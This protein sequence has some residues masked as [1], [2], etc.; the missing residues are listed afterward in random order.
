MT[1]AAKKLGFFEGP[2]QAQYHDLRVFI[3]GVDVSGDLLGTVAVSMADVATPSTA[4]ITLDNALDKYAFT[5]DNA[6][7]SGGVGGKYRDDPF[8]RYSEEPKRKIITRKYGTD[9][10]LTTSGM[11]AKISHMLSDAIAASP[12]LSPEKFGSTTKE[13]TKQ[14]SV[15]AVK[16]VVRSLDKEFF[17]PLTE[18]QTKMMIMDAAER[19]EQL[20]SLNENEVSQQFEDE[21]ARRGAFSGIVAEDVGPLQAPS[22]DPEDQAPKVPDTGKKVGG[23]E[24][25]KQ[26]TN[27]HI[28]VGD[29]VISKHDPI[30]IYA[31]NP[32][33]ENDEWYPVFTG[34]I[35]TVTERTTETTGESTIT[36]NC[37]CIRALMQGMRISMNA[38]LAQFEPVLVIHDAGYF[39][40]QTN[41]N[42]SAWS[43]FLNG[44][45]LEQ[46]VSQLVIGKIDSRLNIGPNDSVIGAS[47]VKSGRVGNFTM[48]D[49]LRYPE[50]A[51]KRSIPPSG[52]AA[53]GVP[54]STGSDADADTLEKWHTISL[55]GYPRLEDGSNKLGTFLTENQVKELGEASYTSG[56]NDPWNRKLH[57]LLPAAGTN[58][59]T[60]TKVSTDDSQNQ[61]VFQNRWEI[62]RT[63]VQTLD[64]QLYTSP[65]GDLLLEF[66][67]YDFVP[68]DFGP[69]WAPLFKYN[70]H[71]IE[72]S[73]TPEAEVIPAGIVVTGN[74]HDFAE[75]QDDLY[76]KLALTVMA[77]SPVIATRFGMVDVQY[78]TIP[79]LKDLV[80]LKAYATLMYQRIIAKSSSISFSGVH[81]PFLL[82]NRPI[83]HERRQRLGTSI[84]IEHSWTIGAEATTDIT[85]QAVRKRIRERDGSYT[86]RFVTGGSQMAISYRLP[87]AVPPEPASS[88]EKAEKVK[89][90]AEEKQKAADNFINMQ[91]AKTVEGMEKSK[92][93]ALDLYE[94][95][96]AMSGEPK[97]HYMAREPAQKWLE[98]VAAAARDGINIKVNSSWRSYEEQQ[99]LFLLWKSG[100]GNEAAEPGKS[101]HQAG[102]AADIYNTK[103]GRGPTFDWM[104][105]NAPKYGFYKTVRS[106][107]HHWEWTGN[108]QKTDTTDPRTVIDKP[109]TN[110]EQLCRS[111]GSGIVVIDGSEPKNNTPTPPSQET[112]NTTNGAAS[113]QL[114]STTEDEAEQSIGL[115]GTAENVPEQNMSIAEEVE[116]PIQSFQ[117]Y[118]PAEPEPEPEE[119]SEESDPE[120]PEDPQDP[121]SSGE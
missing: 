68:E 9:G 56:T 91:K 53:V 17:G 20:Q 2:Y 58:V 102:K 49:V 79:F 46:T 101:R 94:I 61:F 13:A 30:V 44:F 6:D 36:V 3:C 92:S 62:V 47:S 74:L 112:K 97:P 39:S 86:Y 119:A 111:D 103:K 7:A 41:A 43:T 60:L 89:Q 45:S 76:N 29:I 22:R 84:S 83:T 33:T 72:S 11:Q 108:I 42:D 28:D 32:Y 81:R 59:Q 10:K 64:Y 1:E 69:H 106:E 4:T 75:G 115:P 78:H 120:P 26:I 105:K 27:Q 109:L 107:A 52:T 77:Y 37:Y 118:P 66:P 54:A 55:F 71:L 21:K 100:K 23:K 24:V 95:Q 121:Q 93:F 57:M 67:M 65:N 98:L 14:A 88:T 48:G 70:S 8:G 16:K 12:I 25:A 96:P 110:P 40:D 85:I 50:E 117:P 116:E 34:W 104:I 38:A 113:E 87:M 15:D 51:A 35:K 5:P 63:A 73:V 31:H 114:M 99:E 82:P 80:R 19:F 18:E 90:T